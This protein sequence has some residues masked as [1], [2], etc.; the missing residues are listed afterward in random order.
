LHRLGFGKPKPEESV[1]LEIE[2]HVEELA[3]GLVAAGMDAGEARREAERRFGDRRR[4]APKMRHAEEARVRAGHLASGF[5][6]VRASMTSIVRSARREPGFVAAVVVALA[7]GL[8][9][10]A[11]MFGIID[12]LVIGL[13]SVLAFDVAQRTRELG[14]RTALGARKG[15]LLRSVV[16][17]GVG[18]GAS[19]IAIGL[20]VAYLA[21]PYIQDLLFEVSPRDTGV[22]ATVALALLVVSVLASLVPALRATRVDPMAAL[23]AD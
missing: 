10:N 13:Y 17:H 15:R 23:K 19:G 14:I 1:R 7:L 22:F 9:A 18:L 20:A 3:D 21:A 4:Y 5:D 6:L 8:G 16:A 2:H 11:T 12:R